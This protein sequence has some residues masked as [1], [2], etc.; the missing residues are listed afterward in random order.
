MLGIEEPRLGGLLCAVR[1]ASTI[2]QA[3]MTAASGDACAGVLQ[4]RLQ[5]VPDGSCLQ[6][7]VEF[8]YL[9]DVQQQAITHTLYLAALQ[10]GLERLVMR[11]EAHYAHQLEV[12]LHSWPGGDMPPH[13]P[14]V[15]AWG[16]AQSFFACS[17]ARQSQHCCLCGAR[18][19]TAGVLLVL[20]AGLA[21]TQRE[22]VLDSF[23]GWAKFAEQQDRQELLQLCVHGLA[24]HCAAA[25]SR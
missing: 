5:V 3:S 21:D 9:D 7:L 13:G 11:C 14:G 20:S 25:Q 16:N 24:L 17:L 2:K 22:G 10:C 1:Q 12:Q 23:I 15:S 8:L 19:D 4:A 18:A 6:S